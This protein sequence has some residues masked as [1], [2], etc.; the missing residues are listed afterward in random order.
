MKT[1]IRPF[2]AFIACLLVMTAAMG[3]AYL[4]GTDFGHIEIS[5]G[6]LGTDDG[7]NIAYKLYRPIQATEKNPA[8][9]VLLMHGYQNDKDTSAAYAVELARRGIVV[10]AMDSC[11]HGGTSYGM[12]KRGYTHHKLPDWEKTI[13]GPERYLLMMNFNT[14]DFFTNL[15]DVPGNTLG[16]T[17]MGGR[18]MYDYLGSLPFVDAENLG[19]G[20]HS[21]G[22]WSSWSVAS[23]FPGHKAI[24]LQCG[25]LFPKSYY[26]SESIKF[27][28]VLL[29]QARYDEF[30]CFLDYTRSL[31]DE[32]V[33]TRL[34]Y[35][36]FANQ[37]APIEWNKTYGSFADGSARRMELLTGANHRLVTI[38]SRGIATAV[39]WFLNAFGKKASIDYYN[40]TALAIEALKFIGLVAALASTLPLLLLLLKTKFFEPCRQSMPN[41]PETLLTKRKWWYT[42]LVTILISGLSYPFVTQLGH[43]LVPLPESVFRMTIGDGVITWFVFLAVIAYFMLR[44]WYRRGAGKQAGA[45]LY[46]IG[47]ANEDEPDRLPWSVI[48]K[49][50]LLAAI[51][52]L[53]VYMY[54]EV[55]MRLFSLDFRFVWP[56]FKPFTL[57]RLLQ[58]FLYLP[59][60]LVYFLINGGV[61]LYGQMRQ[62]EY[63]SQAVTQLVWWLKGSL[64]ML[65]GL[66]LVCAIEYIPFF[67]GIGPGMDIL[68]SS[69]FGG[70]F[71]SLLIVIAPQFLL[72]FFLSTYT[73]RKTGRVY[74]GSVMLAMLACWVVTAG[75]S[76]L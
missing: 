16:D 9:A 17:S 59:F 13:N 15:P 60:Y 61:K 71:I 28:N 11:G 50:A 45:T 38:S 10:L 70:P 62:R 76:M 39:D 2:V 63:K 57:E 35:A 43:G 7:E 34:R 32:L 73:Y 23:S 37:D 33:R 26:D 41:R 18:L 54:S 8:P 47:L 49:S 52:V 69:T 31:P 12:L 14:C 40:Q 20:G 72:L 1:S 67:A 58:F 25:E 24:V 4:L 19:V 75:S 65:G 66:L 51:L 44:H 36:E 42:A 27:N 5:A 22:T 56:L 74:V 48:G 6:S 30:S 29:L 21:M 64:V 53:S 68:F 46:T 55:F 3:A